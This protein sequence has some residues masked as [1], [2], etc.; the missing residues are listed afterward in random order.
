MPF[1]FHV[2]EKMKVFH[3]EATGEVNDTELMDLSA[4]L[5]HEAAFTSGYP[6]FCDCSAL[7]KVSISARVIELLAKTAGTHTNLLAVIAPLSAAFGLARMYQTFSDPEYARIRV[8]AR[9]EEALAWLA[10]S[11]GKLT[12]HA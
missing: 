8:F 11:A 2:D 3:V 9:A 10:P 6:I 1:S 12:R 7:T 4:R 5:R